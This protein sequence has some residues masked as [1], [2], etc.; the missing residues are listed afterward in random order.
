MSTAARVRFDKNSALYAKSDNS[1]GYC[2]AYNTGG[3]PN[4]GGHSGSGIILSDVSGGTIER[5]VAYNN[6]ALCNSPGG[7][8][9]G[10]WTWDSSNITIQYNES[11]SN[12]TGATSLDGGGFDFDAGVSNSLTPFNH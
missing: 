5:C 9:V 2:Q 10:I 6:G 3:V 4:T 8:P 1:A 11:Y 7:G 12:R